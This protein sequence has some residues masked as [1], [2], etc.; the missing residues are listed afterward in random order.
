MRARNAGGLTRL[1]VRRAARLPGESAYRGHVKAGQLTLACALGRGGL[2]HAKREGDGAT[3]VGT[4]RVLEG[5]FRADRLPRPL[6][7]IP[8]RPTP[9]DLGWCDAPGSPRYNRAARLPLAESH[10]R[11]QRADV[12]YDVVLVLDYNIRPRKAGAGSAIFLHCAKP[13][14]RPTLGCVALAPADLRRLL[15]RLARDVRVIVL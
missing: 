8:L 3:P 2:T 11:M 15:P 12:L 14:Y 10:E 1:V 9:A 4:M 7:R 13:G 5:Y 6:C